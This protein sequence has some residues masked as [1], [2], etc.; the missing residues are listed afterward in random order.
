MLKDGAAAIPAV[1]NQVQM[2]TSRVC[3]AKLSA[4]VYK[5]QAASFWQVIPI[6]PGSG[7]LGHS[8]IQCLLQFT[9]PVLRMHLQTDNGQTDNGDKPRNPGAVDGSREVSTE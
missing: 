9:D 5:R 4:I 2:A 6:T 8:N 7:L 1:A 3:D